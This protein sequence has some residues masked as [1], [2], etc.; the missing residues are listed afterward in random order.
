VSGIVWFDGRFSTPEEARVGVDDPGYL[1]GDGVFAT[2]RAYRGRC[3]RAARHLAGVARGA[4]LL[5]LTLPWPLD[6][7]AEIADEAARRGA[8]EEGDARVRVT[9]TRGGRL[10]VLARPIDPPPGDAYVAGVGAVTLRLRRRAAL[11][12]I[13]KTTSYAPEIAARR[14]AEARGAAEGVQ[15]APGGELACGAMSNL[16]VVAR[17]VLFTPA[18]ES[19]C[20]DGVTRREVL[21]LAPRAGLVAREERLDPALLREADEIFFTSSRVECLPV[22]TLDGRTVGAAFPRAAALRALLREEA[23]A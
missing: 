13:V 4:E 2:L 15:L 3:F 7:V 5:G 9:L 17:D 23:L 21:A 20:R 1:L 11:D 18:L 6:R 8:P 12:P 22:G 14:E 16:F 10:S 19:G